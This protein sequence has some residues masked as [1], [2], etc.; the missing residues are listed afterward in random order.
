[1]KRTPIIIDN[2]SYNKTTLLAKCRSIVATNK[3]NTNLSGHEAC[4]AA[5]VWSKR[6]SEPMPDNIRFGVS[7]DGHYSGFIYSLDNGSEW[8]NMSFKKALMEKDTEAKH[9]ILNAF[10]WAIAAQIS[11]FRRQQ[12]ALPKNAALKEMAA[13]DRFSVHTDH[14]VPMHQ[15]LSDF[16]Q[17]RNTS[18]F[19]V[20]IREQKQSVGEYELVDVELAKAWQ[21]YH[22]KHAVLQLLTA[23]DNYTKAGKY[24]LALYRYNRNREKSYDFS[25]AT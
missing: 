5:W 24:D 12:L 17:E 4:V 21:Q 9:K 25:K 8:E 6:R 20:N 14:I 15:L 2:T 10:R 13:K 3:G 11:T 16:L 7:D 22:T 18:I 19:D 23:S 1:M